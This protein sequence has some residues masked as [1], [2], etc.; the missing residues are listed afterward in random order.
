MNQTTHNSTIRC[1][2]IGGSKIV[3]ADVNHS[4]VATIQAHIQARIPTP[5][6]CFSRFLQA[7]AGLCPDNTDPVSISIAGTIHPASGTIVSAN[8]PC[9]SGRPLAA[10]LT[11]TLGRRVW[12]INDAN[13]FAL[14]ETVTGQAQ[15]HAVVLAVILGT[16]VGGAVVV[17]GQILEGQ[18]GTAGEWGHGP[19]SAHRSS[20]TLPLVQCNCGQ[21]ACVD[22]L[23]GARGLERLYRHINHSSRS[24]PEI[25]KSW[26]SG[27]AKATKAVDVWLDIVSGALANSIN[28]L[29]ASAVPVGG[30]LANSRKLIEAL[31][32]EVITRTLQPHT[33]GLL[34]PVV[35]GP[36]RGLT[37]AAL[38]AYA[39]M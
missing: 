11:Y 29:G 34:Y 31:D 32:R 7:L 15:Q 18:H 28:L 39:H 16:G 26:E 10:D 36:E 5:T 17:N 2:D 24:S 25:V 6:D 12:V 14:A 13:A 20:S 8:I 30:G 27:D 33:A 9:I 35:S 1:F 19:V 4:D 21:H 3:S 37:G 23:G 38:H 22:T